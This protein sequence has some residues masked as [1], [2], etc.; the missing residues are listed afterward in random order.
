M[1]VARVNYT[2]LKYEGESC[3]EF[4]QDVDSAQYHPQWKDI[5]NQDFSWPVLIDLLFLK[6]KS[7]FLQYL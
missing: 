1:V 7:Y 5:F 2:H 6:C 3:E 4:P